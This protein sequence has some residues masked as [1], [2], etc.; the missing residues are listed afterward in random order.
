MLSSS[1]TLKT[2][3]AVSQRTF[4][5]KAGAGGIAG[6]KITGVLRFYKDVGVKDVEGPEKEA[7]E[8]PRKLYAV[9]LDGK[10]VKTPRQQPVRLP[11]RAM[12]YAVAHEWDSQS[13]DIRPATM[14]IMTLASTALDLVYTSS[15]QETIDEMMHYLHTDTVC[16]QVTADQQEKLVA[17]QQKKWKPIR[18][19]FSDLF[20]GEVDVSHGSIDRLA[21]DQQLVDNVRA[22][23]EKLNDFELTAMRTL[24]KECK[25]L[26]TALAV[27][28]RHITAK[29]AMDICRLE[30][31]FQINNWGLVEGGHDLDRVNCAV[32]LSSAS[33][34]LYLLEN[35]H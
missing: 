1:R 10:T 18:K 11:T 13:H 8:E 5:A 20:E 26:I 29:E 30:E 3:S 15:S 7:G 19:W 24:T 17:L 31:E 27:F 33:F 9:T 16:Y 25:S 6:P 21:H 2:L 14:P 23:L 35:K 34:L 4:S 22:H 28:K 12:A 32:K